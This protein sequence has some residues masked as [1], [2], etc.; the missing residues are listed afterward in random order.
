MNPTPAQV[1]AAL[2]AQDDV[3][4]ATARE[5][6]AMTRADSRAHIRRALADNLTDTRA[7]ELGD[8]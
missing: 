5:I 7:A 2:A 8:L 3:L 1:A 4:R 6:L